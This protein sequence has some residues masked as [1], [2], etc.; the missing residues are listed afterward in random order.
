MHIRKNLLEKP[1]KVSNLTKILLENKNVFQILEKSF[2]YPSLEKMSKEQGHKIK[3]PSET[4]QK[5]TKVCPSIIVS[6][7]SLRFVVI[8]PFHATE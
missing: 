7:F 4:K 8:G 1:S 6:S 5:H 3:L 2:H